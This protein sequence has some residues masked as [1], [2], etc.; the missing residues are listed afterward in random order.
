M[1]ISPPSWLID[2][3]QNGSARLMHANRSIG[4]STGGL[5]LET[6]SGEHT[7]SSNHGSALES[8]AQSIQG[9]HRRFT[10]RNPIHSQVTEKGATPT[11]PPIRR[12]D[13]R[14]GPTRDTPKATDTIML[15]PLLQGLL[16]LLARGNWADACVLAMLLVFLWVDVAKV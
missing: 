15:L 4:D 8:T 9:K 7:S 11:T 16:A 14:I 1:L 10:S 5:D 3:Q 12:A 13:S 2:V 6:S